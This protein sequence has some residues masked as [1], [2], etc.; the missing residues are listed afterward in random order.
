MGTTQLYEN[1][2]S[3]KLIQERVITHWKHSV[4]TN[5]Q[6]NISIRQSHQHYHRGKI[7]DTPSRYIQVLNQVSHTQLQNGLTQYTPPGFSFQNLYGCTINIRAL[8]NSTSHSESLTES[9]EAEINKLFA[10]IME[11]DQ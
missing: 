1:G 7:Y 5:I 4:C 8:P 9:S 6:T 2:V 11:P 10:A 3:E